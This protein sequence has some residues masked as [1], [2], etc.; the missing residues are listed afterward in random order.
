MSTHED[1]FRIIKSRLKKKGTFV[2]QRKF[3]LSLPN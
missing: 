2:T 3:T 1:A